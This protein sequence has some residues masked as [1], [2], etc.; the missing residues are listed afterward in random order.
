MTIEGDATLDVDRVRADQLGER[1]DRR[2]SSAA[3][4][5]STGWSRTRSGRSARTSS[6]CRPTA[7]S[8]TSGWAGPATRRCSR[9]TACYLHDSHAFLRKYLRD[10][11]A[12]QRAGRRGPAC[13]RPIRPGCIRGHAATSP[14]RPAGA[15]RSRIIP[16][17]LWQ[18]YG[19]REVLA[20]TLPAMVRWVDFVWSISDGPI[21]RPPSQ[22]G[23][24]RLH[25]RRLA[26]AGRRQ[27]QARADHR[28]RLRGDDLPLHLLACSR[29]RRPRVVGD[30]TVAGGDGGA[31]GRGEAGL[32]RANSSRLRPARLRR[33]D[34]LRARLPARPDPGRACCEAAKRLFQGDDRVD[35]RHASAPASS[36]R[37][38]SCRR[39]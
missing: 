3:I 22:L 38:R 34:V 29:R 10:V 24:A 23:R 12:D 30:E 33:P 14:A 5:W 19:D 1:G 35:R 36:A 16:W 31:R 9:A 18:H 39:W 2:A 6:R 7:R 11:M 26:A 4:R 20:E 27:P 8:A 17:V 15:T 28:R 32:R 13:R 25:L 37:R 21:V